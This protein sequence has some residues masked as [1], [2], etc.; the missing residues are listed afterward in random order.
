MTRFDDLPTEIVSLIIQYI[1]DGPGRRRDDKQLNKCALVNKQFYTATNPLIWKAPV[2]HSGDHLFNK[3]LTGLLESQYFSGQHVQRLN[4]RAL[5]SDRILLLMMKHL[6]H[7]N[8]LNIVD[9]S[10]IT[11]TSIKQLPTHCPNLTQLHLGK[12]VINDLSIQILAQHCHHLHI[13]TLNN[14]PSLTCNLFSALIGTS[15]TALTI[16]VDRS[17]MNDWMAPTHEAATA[18][19]KH[20]T[21]LNRLTR[22]SITGAPLPFTQLLL[23]ATTNINPDTGKRRHRAWPHLVDFSTD[24]F[25]TTRAIGDEQLITF[26][27]SRPRL[28]R[29]SFAGGRMTDALLE[30]IATYLPKIRYLGLI[31]H[32]E[33]TARAVRRLIQHCPLLND[34]ELDGCGFFGYQFPEADT[35]HL[36][37]RYLMALEKDELDDIRRCSDSEPGE[38]D[39]S[40]G[41]DDQSEMDALYDRMD[42]YYY[43]DTVY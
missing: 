19:L 24:E 12:A 38:G 8:L 40:D 2:L 6:S 9:A 30:A 36:D 17:T 7:L 31:N 16:S 13:L 41:L 28:T 33:L 5:R 14:C 15:L 29:F 18:A 22:L 20:L 34:M 21:R 1:K 4:L 25:G 39:E 37:N 43:D 23:T 42:A 11:D 10:R 3:F 32:P 27:K 26:I 35:D